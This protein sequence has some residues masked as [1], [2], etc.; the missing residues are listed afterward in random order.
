M[1]QSTSFSPAFIA[2]ALMRRTRS[3]FPRPLDVLV[4]AEFKVDAVRV[5]DGLLREL[6]AYE[7]GQ[8]A[9]HFAGEG[10]LPVRERAG[11]GK[12]GSDVADGLTIHADAGL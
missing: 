3:K 5:V 6:L 12:A 2:R 1:G 11:A 4:R 7:R 9:A 10:E 8:V